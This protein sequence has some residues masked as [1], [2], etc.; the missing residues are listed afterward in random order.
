MELRSSPNSSPEALVD[1]TFHKSGNMGQPSNIFAIFL[2]YC[3]ANIVLRSIVAIFWLYSGNI[4]AVFWQYWQYCLAQRQ[5]R[6]SQCFGNILATF[7]FMCE[8]HNGQ[9][10][11]K[12]CPQERQSLGILRHSMAHECDGT[13]SSAVCKATRQQ[14]RAE[15]LARIALW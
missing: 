2:Q 13:L 11:C 12:V 4:L 1:L 10:S 3:L 6:V 8:R 7:P 9:P 14:Q 15:S 5:Y